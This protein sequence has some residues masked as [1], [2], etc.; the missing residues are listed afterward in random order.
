MRR[1]LTVL[2]LAA[3]VLAGADASAAPTR[4]GTVTGTIQLG[5]VPPPT[6]GPQPPGAAGEVSVY[7]TDGRI[8]RRKNVRRGRHFR[9]ALSPGRYLLNTGWKLRYRSRQ[10]CRPVTVR[11]TA[12]GTATVSVFTDCELP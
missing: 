10:G 11:V 8:V 6:F 2:A 5:N 7:K 4:T 3:A 12:G 9:F 1:G